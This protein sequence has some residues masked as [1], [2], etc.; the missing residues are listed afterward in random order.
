MPQLDIQRQRFSVGA[1]K[2]NT[3][4]ERDVDLETGSGAYNKRISSRPQTFPARNLQLS[5]NSKTDRAGSPARPRHLTRKDSEDTFVSAKETPTNKATEQLTTNNGRSPLRLHETTGVA[6]VN[7]ESPLEKTR[8][9][10]PTQGD[11]EHQMLQDIAEDQEPA[12]I[13]EQLELSSSV[14]HLENT[15]ENT[16]SENAS[17]T[18]TVVRKSSLNFASLPAR[19]PMM[20]KKS[21]G[22]AVP[23]A[24]L[25]GDR[26]ST[27]WREENKMDEDLARVPGLALSSENYTVEDKGLHDPIGT[28]LRGQGETDRR[29]TT[30]K[31]HE[32]MAMLRQSTQQTLSAAASA[33]VPRTVIEKNLE[34][35]SQDREDNDDDWIGPIAGSMGESKSSDPPAP[36]MLVNAVLPGRLDH[37]DEM[38]KLEADIF[39]IPASPQ[40]LITRKQV[41]QNGSTNKNTGLLPKSTLA[42]YPSLNSLAIESNT[43]AG[44][45]SGKKHGEGPLSASKA[46]LMSVF[47]SAKGIF[48][49]SAGVSAQAKMETLSS[50]HSLR[51]RNESQLT[52]ASTMST[53]SSRT[54]VAPASLYPTINISSGR[55][56][57]DEK[58][59]NSIE[60][61]P[62]DQK[63]RRYSARLANMS[64]VDNNHDSMAKMEYV[65][66]VE[67]QQTQETV[68][69]DDSTSQRGEEEQVD[70]TMTQPSRARPS[71]LQI[72]K[73]EPRRP[74]RPGKDVGPK[75]KPAPVSIRVASQRVSAQ[76]RLQDGVAFDMIADWSS[77]T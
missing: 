31:L 20:A 49:S 27:F 67:T 70:I 21:F 68:K 77:W 74:L 15:M 47:K 7:Q 36:G 57:E 58:P 59:L 4:D 34:L 60:Q 16:P 75:S 8:E 62:Q 18:R 41:A 63:T 23:K 69:S 43:P 14:Q 28:G 13:V 45:P 37:V 25:L 39:A 30:Q 48:A 52:L 56:A 50:S 29:T 24:A 65:L 2:E 61:A 54:E 1:G 6:G 55:T 22:G 17:P 72:A 35:V 71:G 5:V 64:I 12:E 44:S 33:S 38:S 53:M 46:K 9:A 42:T 73:A 3:V 66:P 19:A 10:S 11:G 40:K 26:Q 51:S 32:R 76:Q